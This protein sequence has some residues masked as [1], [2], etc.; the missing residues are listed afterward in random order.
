MDPSALFG[1][2]TFEVVGTEAVRK[3]TPHFELWDGES[4]GSNYGGKPIVDFAGKPAF[5]ELAVL[6]TLDAAGWDGVWVTHAGG[7]EKHRRGFWGEQRPCEVPSTVLA[8]LEGIRTGRGGTSRGTWDLV[9]WPHGSRAPMP[10]ELS[11]VECKW[12]GRDAVKGDQADWFRAARAAGAD[13]ESF[14]IVEWSLRSR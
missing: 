3:A 9:C 8:F 13:L 5:A 4:P 2:T 14:L 10:A 11:F 1:P 6:W 7:R 12:R